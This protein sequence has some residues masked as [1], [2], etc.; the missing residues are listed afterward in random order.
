MAPAGG[1]G[2]GMGPG[3]MQHWRINRRN[4]PAYGMMS[5]QERAEHQTRMRSMH[6]YD[7]C[8]AY[9]GQFR[10]QMAARAK[11]RR[12]PYAPR[13]NAC[14]VMRAQGRVK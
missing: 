7:D 4:T 10:E 12:M 8:V 9:M 11:E 5:S 13:N 6:S 1:P 3:A 14:D 2:Q